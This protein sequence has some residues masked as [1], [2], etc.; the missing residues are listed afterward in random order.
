VLREINEILRE[1]VHPAVPAFL[2]NPVV[3]LFPE[4]L[5]G[6]IYF[7]LALDQV[8]VDVRSRPCDFCHQRF[9]QTNRKRRFCSDAH[10]YSYFYHERKARLRARNHRYAGSGTVEVVDRR[11]GKELAA[12]LGDRPL[13]LD[14]Q[15]VEGTEVDQR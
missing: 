12:L 3:R 9:T 6:A 15:P 11:E 5:L 13:V 4:T 2:A 8:G 7:R 14:P 10:R 1:H